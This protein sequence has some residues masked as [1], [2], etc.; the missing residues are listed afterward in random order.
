[1]KLKLIDQTNTATNSLTLIFLIVTSYLLYTASQGYENRWF[2]VSGGVV[3]AILSASVISSFIV[4][5]KKELDERKKRQ[6]Q[7]S[8]RVFVFVFIFPSLV[9]YASSLYTVYNKY[10]LTAGL[11]L[12][13]AFVLVSLSFVSTFYKY[14]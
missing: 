12:F 13:W 6:Q 8:T 10:N 14:I 2:L 7:Q 9:I 11:T 1:M 4:D 5:N 3:L